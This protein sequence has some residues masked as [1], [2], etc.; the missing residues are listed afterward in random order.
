MDR[1]REAN[2]KVGS[3]RLARERHPDRALAGRAAERRALGP[4]GNLGLEGPFFL[5]TYLPGTLPGYV[6]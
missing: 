3:G 4:E 1:V 2:G 5:P 6:S